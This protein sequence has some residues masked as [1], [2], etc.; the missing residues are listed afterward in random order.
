VCSSDLGKARK[1]PTR[2]PPAK[3]EEAVAPPKE[4]SFCKPD[5]RAPRSAPDRKRK[6]T[7]RIWEKTPAA[8]KRIPRGAQDGEAKCRLR[9][10]RESP[11]SWRCRQGPGRSFRASAGLTLLKQQ[12]ARAR[13]GRGRRR[14]KGFGQTGSKRVGKKASAFGEDPA[15]SKGRSSLRFEGLAKI[16][17]LEGSLFGTGSG[18][19]RIEVRFGSRLRRVAIEELVSSGTVRRCGRV[20]VRFDPTLRERVAVGRLAFR[21]GVRRRKG[22]SLLRS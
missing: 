22:R 20:E 2:R 18:G 12:R 16:R 1:D 3:A 15:G 7:N 6:P 5:V 14:R 4:G 10:M 8:P 17:R 19:S 9:R 13:S 11:R 21:P